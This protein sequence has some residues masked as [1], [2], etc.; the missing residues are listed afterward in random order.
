LAKI[1]EKFFSDCVGGCLEQPPPPPRTMGGVC[2][3]CQVCR[4]LDRFW[5][6]LVPTAGTK[7]WQIWQ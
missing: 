3:I 2:Q 4:S 6:S 1:F 5:E 7:P